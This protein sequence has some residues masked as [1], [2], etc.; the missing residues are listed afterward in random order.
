MK[1]G[2]KQGR[3]SGESPEVGKSESPFPS[4]LPTP[5]L[6]QRHDLG[7]TFQVSTT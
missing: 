6:R 4:T 7:E 1:E 5:C 2:E 3:E